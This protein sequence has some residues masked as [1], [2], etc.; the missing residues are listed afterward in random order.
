MS[1]YFLIF[2]LNFEPTK[3]NNMNTVIRKIGVLTSGGDSPGM[4]ACVRAVVRTAHYY[5]ID[6]FGIMEGYKGMLEGNFKQLSNFDVAGIISRGGTLLRTSRCPEFRELAGRQKAY[7]NLK[8]EGV[9]ALVIIGGDGSFAGA[10]A[11]EQEFGIPSIGTPGTIDNDLFGTDYTIGFD[12]AVNTVVKAIDQIRD[13]AASHNRLFFIEVMGRDSGYIAVNS[14]VAGGG[15]AVLFPEESRDLTWLMDYLEEKKK[16][17]ILSSI[18]V[19]A[20]G[21]ETGGAV[22][23]NKLIKKTY[24]Q[25]DTRVTVL[26]HLQRGGAPSAFD[27]ILASRLGMHAVE[28]L[29]QGQRNVMAGLINNELV[30]TPFKTAIAGHKKEIHPDLVKMSQI[31]VV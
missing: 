25:Y 20:E 13:T 27:R 29:L 17:K 19:V 14:C 7:E 12:T 11:F 30:F 23:I 8:K 22:E 16:R 21:D 4:N 9:D 18:V 5:N 28:G 6:V 31:L 26:G 2:N 15:E 10:L 1:F 3:M 24:P